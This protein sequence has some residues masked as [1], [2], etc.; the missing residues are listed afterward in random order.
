MYVHKV[1]KHT[2]M[3]QLGCF[4]IESRKGEYAVCSFLFCTSANWS[5]KQHFYWLGTSLFFNGFLKSFALNHSRFELITDVCRARILVDASGLCSVDFGKSSPGPR[6]AAHSHYAAF[7]TLACVH[8]YEKAEHQ[9]LIH[10]LGMKC[11]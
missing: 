6:F 2:V 5:C 1:Q 4:R 9:Y 11:I 10:F 7:A 3:K 8:E